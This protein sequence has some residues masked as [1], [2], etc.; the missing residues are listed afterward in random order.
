LTRPKKRPLRGCDAL[1]ESGYPEHLR[2]LGMEVPS[3]GDGPHIA[4][5]GI[6]VLSE[7]I[8]VRNEQI[9]IAIVV[10][11]KETMCDIGPD[12]SCERAGPR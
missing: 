4:G 7:Y 6:G 10:G 9:R 5:D 11:R 12:T 3:D 1:E 2:R 8:A